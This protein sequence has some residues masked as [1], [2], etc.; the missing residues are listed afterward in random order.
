M[1]TSEHAAPHFSLVHLLHLIRRFKAT[2]L[3]P[4]LLG[5]A[6]A[7]ALY[8]GESPYY[9][10]EARLLVRYVTEANLVEE[11]AGAGRIQTPDQRGQNIINSEVDILT[12]RV[13][14]EE[15]V[16][17]L[18][19]SFVAQTAEG[20][21]SR[22]DA[23][24]QVMRGLQVEAPRRSNVIR[25]QFASF[26]PEVAQKVL[27]RMVYRYL[28][29]HAVIHKTAGE[30]QF[31]SQQTDLIRSRL[32]QTE[33]DLRRLKQ[34]IG[35]TTVGETKSLLVARLE[36]L[37]ASL[38][39]AQSS[40]AAAEARREFAHGAAPTDQVAADAED[41]AALSEEERQE[42][43]DLMQ[44]LA[45][46]REREAALLSSFS[47]RSKLV[48]DVRAEIASVARS[49]RKAAG[50][51]DLTKLDPQPAVRSDLA[52]AQ[53]A[54]IAAL[55]A[56]IK[57]I[58]S[59]VRETQKSID[60]LNQREAQLVQLQRQWE[61]L[62]AN[63]RSYTKSLEHAQIQEALNSGQQSNI[64]IVQ[65][66]TLPI[67]ATFPTRQRNATFCLG[68][69]LGIGVLLALLRGRARA[70]RIVE[71]ADV[72]ATLGRPVL[73]AM[74]YASSRGLLGRP[75][76]GSAP[77]ALPAHAGAAGEAPTAGA[78]PSQAE[79][80]P[81]FDTLCDRLLMTLN[82]RAE[83]PVILGLAAC[84]EGAGVS[85]VSAGLGA[86]LSRLGAGRVLLVDASAGGKNGIQHGAAGMIDLLRDDSGR[87]AIL[88]PNLYLLT[89]HEVTEGMGHVNMFQR[90]K[91]L[92]KTLESSSYRYVILELPPISETSSALVLA[93][94]LHGVVLV[95]EA[96]KVRKDQVKRA[97]E[98]LRDSGATV[99]GSILNKSRQRSWEAA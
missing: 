63:Y 57:V 12:S 22:I 39:D 19:P 66:A 58:R 3:L 81:Y 84:N 59:Y 38:R 14:I 73:I 92:L 98:L 69:G 88:Q 17:E 99:L 31:L 20:T 21:P 52:L 10:S 97:E 27:D 87:V 47:G 53:E 6:G 11:E 54:E 70:Q 83:Q 61:M 51:T 72:E 93:R 86:A 15:V 29:K 9:L 68:G 96:D 43:L 71:T 75:G 28:E 42:I 67:T 33:E 50:N 94:H 91:D 32:M 56:Q 35:V 23:I 78:A 2:V 64:S 48:E 80:R 77:L 74:P 5:A 4:T 85:T 79:M 55:Q 95:I 76:A 30:Y 26:S 16:D 44:R 62:D 36:D 65:P 45:V 90:L 41:G 40:L 34:D 7:A 1:N 37:N 82:G 49:L 25:L 46:L 13:L 8:W 18:G 24:L 89:A 60:E